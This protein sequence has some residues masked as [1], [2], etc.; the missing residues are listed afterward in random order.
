ME[1]ERARIPLG[2]LGMSSWVHFGGT[3]GAEGDR[4]RKHP[5]LEDGFSVR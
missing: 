4:L 3:Q 5:A 2:F 1:M